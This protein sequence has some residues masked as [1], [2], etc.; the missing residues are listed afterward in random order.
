MDKLIM[1]D[2]E[3]LEYLLKLLTS[4]IDTNYYIL[5]NLELNK[6]LANLRKNYKEK[7]VDLINHRLLYDKKKFESIL[8]ELED[9]FKQASK[10]MNKLISAN[11]ENESLAEK[12]FI[13]IHNKVK[14]LISACQIDM[15]SLDPNTGL[16]KEECTLYNDVISSILLNF[17]HIKDEFDKK[18]KLLST[19]AVKAKD[20]LIK[21]VQS[22]SHIIL[23]LPD[24]DNEGICVCNSLQ[25]KL[26]VVKYIDKPGKEENSIISYTNPSS[27]ENIFD[28]LL[29]SDIAIIPNNIIGDSDEILKLC[30]EVNTYTRMI[31]GKSYKQELLDSLYKRF[32]EIEKAEEKNNNVLSISKRKKINEYIEKAKEYIYYVCLHDLL[33]LA[34]DM[35]VAPEFSNVRDAIDKELENIDSIMQKLENDNVES[36]D[37]YLNNEKAKKKE[38]NVILKVKYIDSK[39]RKVKKK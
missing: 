16:L 15:Y 23:G 29:I 14:K 33:S 13:M 22:S 30:S 21:E 19:N 37:G 26:G 32:P 24:K 1:Y 25:E 34:G 9:K 31:N 35:L 5:K 7:K 4:Q 10:L 3:L 38:N 12:E 18:R 27:W 8:K 36:L 39:K 2:M 20:D 11:L 17:P 28:Y 6:D